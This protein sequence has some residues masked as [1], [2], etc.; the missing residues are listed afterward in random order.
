MSAFR[1]FFFDLDTRKEIECEANGKTWL[2]TSGMKMVAGEFVKD[3]CTFVEVADSTSFR[4]VAGPRK[5]T[6]ADFPGRRVAVKVWA[7][8]GV[9][10][11]RKL[12]EA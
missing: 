11:W 6:A 10:D 8:G 2:G 1:A 3:T 5:V 4:H 7:P 9:I 12:V